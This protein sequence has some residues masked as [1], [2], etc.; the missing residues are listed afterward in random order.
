MLD[1]GGCQKEQQDDFVELTARLGGKWGVLNGAKKS[2]GFMQRGRM[3]KRRQQEEGY[4]PQ[5]ETEWS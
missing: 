2:K 5:S 1:G 4:R 3:L